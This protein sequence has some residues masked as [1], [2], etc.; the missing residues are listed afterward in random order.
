[1]LAER[2]DQR[3][4]AGVLSNAIWTERK[5]SNVAG[6]VRGLLVNPSDPSSN[7]IWTGSAGGG[8]WKGT[9]ATGSSIQ[10]SS[11]N[12]FLTNLAVTTIASGPASRPSALYCCIGE[13]YFNADAVQGAGIWKS[14][15]GGSI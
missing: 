11:A 13:D 2:A 6:R 15:D 3:P 7:T 12:L 1:M 4:M 10:W 14:T 8:L 5:P 9:N